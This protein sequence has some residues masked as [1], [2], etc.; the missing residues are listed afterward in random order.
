M[1][2]F[3]AELLVSSRED[4]GIVFICKEVMTMYYKQK[5]EYSREDQR[6]VCIFKN[7][8]VS[9][10]PIIFLIL[11]NYH[12]EIEKEVV[13]ELIEK[14][15]NQN[16]I[17]NLQAEIL[18]EVL[19]LA[20]EIIQYETYKESIPFITSFID[21]LFENHHPSLPTYYSIVTKFYKICLSKSYNEVHHRI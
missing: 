17:N 2:N 5:Y 1:P 13:R 16:L 15:Y 4:S 10:F 8:K 20:C 21:S 7:L 6:I 12:N 19:E 3:I 18:H 9:T 14:I 11:K